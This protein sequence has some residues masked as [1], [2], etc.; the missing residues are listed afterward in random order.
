MRFENPRLSVQMLFKNSVACFS[1]LSKAKCCALDS[2]LV[3]S[4]PCGRDFRT[5]GHA[6]ALAQAL[7]WARPGRTPQDPVG[8]V[9]YDAALPELPLCADP[10]QRWRD[11][12]VKFWSAAF[13]SSRISRRSSAA[14]SVFIWLLVGIVL[15]I[16]SLIRRHLPRIGVEFGRG[17]RHE[18]SYRS[19]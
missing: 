5:T 14:S 13:S 17:S 3:F 10:V 6:P 16:K 18:F 15:M 9:T 4:L 7:A 19:D 11:A 12:P 2:W 8:W 1:G